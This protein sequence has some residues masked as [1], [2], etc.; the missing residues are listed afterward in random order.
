MNASD[1]SLSAVLLP[2]S[3]ITKYPEVEIIGSLIVK[4]ASK[5]L[6]LR[7]QI[8]NWVFLSIIGFFQTLAS[9]R[10]K[11]KLH[12]PLSWIMKQWLKSEKP[13]SFATGLHSFGIKS[14]TGVFSQYTKLTSWHF[15]TT[16][17]GN[18]L[19][20]STRWINMKANLHLWCCSE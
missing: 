7:R 5:I 10:R 2:L 11:D 1:S 9:W 18:L 6:W 19:K 8:E 17:N 15:C 20:M 3:L 16:F 13:C 4:T 12:G 14:L